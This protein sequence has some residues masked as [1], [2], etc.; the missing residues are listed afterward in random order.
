MELWQ[1]LAGILTTSVVVGTAVATTVRHMLRAEFV[2][3]GQHGELERRMGTM[4]KHI[5]GVP[6]EHDVSDL[7][8]RLGTMETG[9]AVSQA[10]I[11]GVNAGLKRVEHLVQ[12]LV[13]HQL[14]KRE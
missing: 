13:D 1:A 7:T 12:M 3:R 9:V 6:S 10:S 2:T 14:R 4:E 5:V 11:E 8:R